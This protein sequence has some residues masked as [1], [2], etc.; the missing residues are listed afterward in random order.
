[1]RIYERLPGRTHAAQ[2]QRKRYEGVIAT[3]S[4]RRIVHAATE[5]EHDEASE[6][7]AQP[8]EPQRRDA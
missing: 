6:Q 4:H 8:I 7:Q 1:M 2:P 3:L 5:P